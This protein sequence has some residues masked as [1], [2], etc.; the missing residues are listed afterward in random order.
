MIE[1]RVPALELLPQYKAAVERNWSP[2]TTRSLTG[3]ELDR[4]YNHPKDFLAEISGED[5]SEPFALPDGT[6][7]PRLPGFARWVW[8]GDFCGSLNFRWQPGTSQLPPHVMGHIGYAVVPWKQNRGYAKEGLRLLLRE[9]GKLG[10]AYVEITTDPDNVASQKV[11]L[12]NRG[13]LVE[14]FTKSPHYDGTEGLRYRIDF[15]NNG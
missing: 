9:I 4:L 12:A 5:I 1:L 11:I 7:V 10:L 13:E 8:D 15:A 2:Y 14:R 6:K 3:S